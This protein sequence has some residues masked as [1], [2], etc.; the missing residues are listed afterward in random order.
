MAIVLT[1]IHLFQ[2]RKYMHIELKQ[3]TKVLFFEN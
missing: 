1:S 2:M 3:N